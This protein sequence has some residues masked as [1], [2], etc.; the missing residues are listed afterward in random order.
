M[1]TRCGEIR[2][3]QEVE[4]EVETG[5]GDKMWRNKV[6]TGGGDRSGDWRWRQEVEK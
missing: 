5:D 4:I 1:E 6:V 2:W 3:K